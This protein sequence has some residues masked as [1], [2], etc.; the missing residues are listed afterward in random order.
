M[1]ALLWLASVWAGP[2]EDGRDAY[3][4]GDYAGAVEIWESVEDP[5]AAVLY[6]LGAA[7]YRAG[8][9]PRAIAAWRA[10]TRRRP[11]DGDLAHNLALA[12]AGLGDRPPPVDPEPRWSALARPEEV[13]AVAVALLLAAAVSLSGRRA[14]RVA[15]G[16][17]LWLVGL[18]LGVVAISGQRA[19]DRQPVA[20]VVDAP[21]RARDAA[22]PDGAVRFELQPGTEV[23][24]E[25]RLDG[26]TLARTGDGRRGW[27]PSGGLAS[28][29]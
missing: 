4:R 29:D 28:H 15:I 25:R 6:D 18:L 26:F 8:D 27:V 21:A 16:G 9:A 3:D 12:R 11:R 13:G 1:I 14:G 22:R 23:L 2:M 5:S 19:S 20:V 17:G 24:V 10:A 7:H